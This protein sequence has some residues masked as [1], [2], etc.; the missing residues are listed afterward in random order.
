MVELHFVGGN[1]Y[2]KVRV[3]KNSLEF[4]DSSTGWYF[5]KIID[6]NNVTKENLKKIR[7]SK[8]D[9]FYSLWLK[10]LKRFRKMSKEEVVKELILD[11]QKSGWRLAR[12]WE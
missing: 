8:G 11:V 6:G 7:D 3:E 1:K 2:M 4:A 12:K 9:E 5:L 10:D